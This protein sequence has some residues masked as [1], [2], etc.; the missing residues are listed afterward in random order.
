[1]QA[2]QQPVGLLV[3]RVLPQQPLGVDDRLGVLAARRHQG[4]QS[5]Q[6]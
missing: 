4:R 1:V 6:R 2:H 5:L 3:Q